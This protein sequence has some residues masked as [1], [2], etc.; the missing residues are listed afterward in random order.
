MPVRGARMWGAIAVAAVVLVLIV[1]AATSCRHYVS[2][3]P[4]VV[5]TRTVHPPASPLV[6]QATKKPPLHK[7]IVQRLLHRKY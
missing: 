2:P 5:V 6:S 3:A 1:F 4:T 7:R